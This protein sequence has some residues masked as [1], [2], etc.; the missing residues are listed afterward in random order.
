MGLNLP[1]DV[2]SPVTNTQHVQLLVSALPHWYPTGLLVLHKPAACCLLFLPSCPAQ[3]LTFA[4]AGEWLS[5]FP[6]THAMVYIR[7]Q[8]M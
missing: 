3:K 2:F 6:A 7:S 1:L 4:K 8:T 5:L